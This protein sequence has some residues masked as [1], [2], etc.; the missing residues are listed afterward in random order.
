MGLNTDE[1]LKMY[2]TIAALSGDVFYRYDFQKDVM[3]LFGGPANISRYGSEIHNFV[4]NVRNHGLMSN[5]PAAVLFAETLEKGF[6]DYFEKEV[7][8]STSHLENGWYK[9]IGKIEYDDNWKA[10]GIVGKLVYIGDIILGDRSYGSTVKVSG[11]LDRKSFI[12]KVDVLCYEK[13][14]TKSVMLVLAINELDKLCDGDNLL[15]ENIMT[16]VVQMIKRIYP[17]NI[18]Y[19]RLRS[20]EMGIFYYGNDPERE[21]IARIEEL[22]NAITSISI[23]NISYLITVNG[24]IA[25]DISNDSDAFSYLDRANIAL[26]VSKNKAANNFEYFEDECL[27]NVEMTKDTVDTSLIEQALN[28]LGETGDLSAAI[29]GL[30]QQIGFKYKLDCISIQEVDE[31]TN[32]TYPAYQWYDPDNYTVQAK[33]ARLPFDNVPAINWNGESIMIINDMANYTGDNE[34]VNKMKSI[35]TKSAV[36]CKYF[37]A[38]EVGGWVSFE[39]HTRVHEWRPEEITTCKLAAKFISASLLNMKTYFALLKKEEN[40]KT[41]DTVTGLVKYDIFKSKATRYIELNQDKK[42]AIISFGFTN[43]EKVNDIY[44]REVGDYILKA[45]SVECGKIEDR[46]II[47]SRLNADNFVALVNQF[48]SRGNQLSTAIIDRMTSQFSEIC[49]QKCPAANLSVNTGII[50]LPKKVDNLENYVEKASVA[51]DKARDDD[52]VSCVFAY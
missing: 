40:Q 25:K 44:G 32:R 3:N 11:L 49:K 19:G 47:G 37:T 14:N 42:L 23:N 46:I 13:N 10:C 50:F 9:A 45:F 38:G 5:S 20:C 43:F 18:V 16:N 22:K 12:N 17:N 4:D 33:M 2:K 35:E 39:T 48:D 24:G 26:L 28:V 1:E 6:P 36:I 52:A 51:R 34:I 30:L 31:K 21:F 27:K 8:M 41:H 15:K 7:Q 29:A